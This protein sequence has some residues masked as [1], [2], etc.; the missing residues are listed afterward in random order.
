[1]TCPHPEEFS[2]LIDRELAPENIPELERHVEECEKCRR[3]FLKISAADRMLALTLG[4]VDLVRE[5]LEIRA[6]KED[7]IPDSVKR[8]LEEFGQ[9]ERVKALRKEEAALMRR[10]RKRRTIFLLLILFLLGGFAAS[11]QPSPINNLGEARRSGA[12]ITGPGTVTLYGGARVKLSKDARV[13]FWCT[14]RWERPKIRIIAGTVTLETGK[15]TAATD[16]GVIKIPSGSSATADPDGKISV[17][18]ADSQ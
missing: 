9:A 18:K 8:R 5:V 15:L 12:F 17:S 13:R 2:A 11:I 4:R 10:K 7:V 14:F 3:L 6:G 16:A 1:V